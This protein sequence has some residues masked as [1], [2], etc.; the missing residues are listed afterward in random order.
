MNFNDIMGSK[1]VKYKNREILLEVALSLNK[2]LFDENKISYK[3]FKYTEE[4][5]L[6]ELKIVSVSGANACY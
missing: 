4:N 6:K 5:I 1:E 3:M 2:E